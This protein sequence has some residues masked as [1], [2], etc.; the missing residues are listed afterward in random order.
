VGILS[1][2]EY[3]AKINRGEEIPSGTVVETEDPDSLARFM[4]AY[5]PSQND[6]IWA[7][8]EELDAKRWVDLREREEGAML[9]EPDSVSP[10]TDVL[11]RN[12]SRVASGSE[13]VCVEAHRLVSVDRQG[14]YGHPLDDFG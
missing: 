9:S 7:S 11:G 1:E 14:D 13:S 6:H 2:F 8:Q 4:N 3:R 10:F 12:S 5:H